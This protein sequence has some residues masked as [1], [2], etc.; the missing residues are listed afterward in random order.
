MLNIP[1]KQVVTINDHLERAKGY[2][3][4]DL[5]QKEA[6]EWMKSRLSTIKP[7]YAGTLAQIVDENLPSIEVAYVEGGY[8]SCQSHRKLAKIVGEIF[9][10]GG[11]TYEAKLMGLNVDFDVVKSF[12][13][14]NLIIAPEHEA[15]ICKMAKELGGSQDFIFPGIT[16]TDETTPSLEELTYLSLKGKPIISVRNLT[17]VGGLRNDKD[18]NLAAD[19]PSFVNL[20][21]AEDKRYYPGMGVFYWL[22]QIPIENIPLLTS[23]KEK[24]IYQEIVKLKESVEKTPKMQAEGLSILCSAYLPPWSEM[25]K[26]LPFTGAGIIGDLSS[27]FHSPSY[28]FYFLNHLFKELAVGK[29]PDDKMV[30]QVRNLSEKLSHMWSFNSTIHLPWTSELAGLSNN[31][32]GQI[33]NFK[34]DY[35]MRYGVGYQGKSIEIREYHFGQNR[36]FPSEYSGKTCHAIIVYPQSELF[37]GKSCWQGFDST[38]DEWTGLNQKGLIK[39]MLEIIKNYD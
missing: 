2:V 32:M 33:T 24:L 9:L 15:I 10:V 4:A 17:G 37:E 25:K 34:G 7:E 1:P 29:T 21:V 19:L 11:L 28:E 8:D 39:T 6:I 12:I 23:F 31:L 22:T 20:K 30:N 3:Y 38:S 27:A 16:K 26:W 13:S 14:S 18:W 36:A 5:G 35:C